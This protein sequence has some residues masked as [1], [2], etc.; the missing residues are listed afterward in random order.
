MEKSSVSYVFHEICGLIAG[1]RY[2]IMKWPTRDEHLK[3]AAQI[4]SR[5]HFPNCVGFI[6]GCHIEI[7]APANNPTDFYNRK[8]THSIILQAVCDDSLKLVDIYI[9]QTGRAH[10]A[11]VFRESPL[12]DQIQH[13][14]VSEKYHILADS[15][16]TLNMNIMTPYKDDGFLTDAEV[17]Y[18]IIHS[19]A[20]S[21]IERCLGLLKTK[22]EIEVFGN[23]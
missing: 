8:E 17:K 6:D 12:G 20:R 13:I 19:K 9:G 23:K 15:G 5:Y 1:C 7:K 2:E 18:N 16:Y 10:D 4:R 11:G 22:F 14:I 3:T 21:T